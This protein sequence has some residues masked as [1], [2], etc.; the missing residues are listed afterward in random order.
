MDMKRTVC[1]VVLV[2]NAFDVENSTMMED[3]TRQ[4]KLAY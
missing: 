3:E 4:K 1:V 2:F